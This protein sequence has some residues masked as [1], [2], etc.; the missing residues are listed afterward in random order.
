[1]IGSADRL[2][3]L[4]ESRRRC[5]A[6]LSSARSSTADGRPVHAVRGVDLSVGAGEFV[7]VMGPSGSGKSTL[8]HLIGGLEMPTAG[9]IWLDGRRVDGLS[10]ARWAMLRRRH[11]GFVFQFFNLVSN[12]T[13]ADNVEL[14]G[15][16]ERRHPAP[17]QGAPGRTAGRARPGRQGGLRAVPAVRR[18]A[19]AGG[20]RAGAG[21]PAEPAARRRADRQPRQR[22]HLPTC[23]ACLPGTR[24]GPGDR[25]GHPRRPGG[26]PG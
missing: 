20:A 24:P 4:T 26:Q 13:V 18:R 15:A 19:A 21:Q 12:M 8:L 3:R 5:C 9:E 6:P 2:E 16:D 11:I 23:C 10:Q 17:G 25:A 22:E 7:A 14:A 1:M